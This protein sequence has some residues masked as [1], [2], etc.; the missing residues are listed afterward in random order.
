M[1]KFLFQLIF[2]PFG[3]FFGFS[4]PAAIEGIKMPQ[5]FSIE[6]FQKGLPDARSM[7]LSE[8][9]ILFVGS[10]G[11]EGVR[12]VIHSAIYKGPLKT[13]VVVIGKELNRPNG[14]AVRDGDLFVAENSRI[15]RYPKIED[16][17]RSKKFNYIVLKDDY[18]TETHHGWK[19]LAFGPDGWLYVPV[20]SPCNI[21]DPG[22]RFANLTRISPDGKKFEVYAKGIRNTVGFDWDPK[23]KNLWFTDNGRDMWGNDRPTDELN[24]ATK[25]SLHFGYP[26]CHEGNLKDPEF[27]SQH[28]CSEFEKPFSKLGPHVA[29]LGMKFYRGKQFPEKYRGKIFIAEHGSWNRDPRLGYRITL[30]DPEKPGSYEIFAEGWLRKNNAVQGRPVDILELPD[31]SLLV[32]DDDDGQIYRIRYTKN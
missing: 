7:A 30:V 12:A 3:L 17:L 24:T 4:A 27:G 22:E 18:P 26:Y 6:V 5:G 9:G 16:Q 14:V 32:S 13:E 1:R 11:N 29:A 15:L 2:F 10:R 23:T 31:G 8:S 20:G 21:C 25:A 19:Y 28:E